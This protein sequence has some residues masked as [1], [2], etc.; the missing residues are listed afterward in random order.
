MKKRIL[1]LIQSPS[2]QAMSASALLTAL[3]IPEDEVKLFQ[4]M[5][6]SLVSTGEVFE[7]FGRYY[8]PQEAGL[9]K[10]TIS[11]KTT[12]GFITSDYFPEDL[13]V[14][15]R[16]LKS[17][18]SGDT[19][20]FSVHSFGEGEGKKLE[21][22]VE[23][24]LSHARSYV[25]GV[26]KTVRGR[27]TLELQG[28]EETRFNVTEANGAHEGDLVKAQ[29]ERQ[30]SSVMEGPI[31]QN[32][33]RASDPG[34]D[35]YG[36]A[37]SYGFS[38]DFPDEVL[39]E[40]NTLPDG[41]VFEEKKR[42]APSLPLI[43]TVDGEDTKDID[44]AVACRK[45]ADGSYTLGVYIADVSYYVR[46]E[47]SLDKE[48]LSRG[49]SVY[50]IDKVLPMLPVRLSNEL[51]SLNEGTP[52]LAEACEMHIAR[53]GRVTSKSLFETVMTSSHRMT[54][55][56]IQ[57]ILDGD[58]ETSAAYADIVNEVHAMNELAQVL[59]KMH[60]GKG[61]IDFDV[62]EAKIIVNDQGEPIDIVL[63]ERRD[64]EKIIEQFMII[65]NETVAKT[66]T[67]AHL[68]MIYRVH[69][70]PRSERIEEYNK[71]IA[72][73]GYAPLSAKPTAKEVQLFMSRIPERDEFLRSALIRAMAKACY[74]E[75]NIGHYGLASK[76][77]THFTSPIRRYPDLLVHRLLRR[78]VFRHDLPKAG[79]GTDE[80]EESIASIA[81]QASK[82]ERDATSA[83]FAADDLKKAQYMASHV[84]ETFSGVISGVQKFGFFVELANTV[85]GL[86][87]TAILPEGYALQ[88][89]PLSLACPADV[90][91]ALGDEVQVILTKADTKSGKIDFTVV[92]PKGARPC[93]AR[94]LL[95]ATSL[96]P[97]SAHHPVKTAHHDAPAAKAHPSSHAP[98]ALHAAPAKKGKG[99]DTAKKNKSS[100]TGKH[101][102]HYTTSLGDLIKEARKHDR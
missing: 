38:K 68:P 87:A 13:Y 14:F 86:V 12:F 50:M 34:N 59:T 67:D 25:V 40:A 47:T 51:C 29:I 62:P 46:P 42:K 60:E 9:Y 44:D 71:E 24:V 75:E 20:I 58:A 22:S 100:Q 56:K 81:R 11:V 55:T 36:I 52:K 88:D 4:E 1:A 70:V 85:E 17:A 45:E 3:S 49:T 84:G 30:N 23:R 90:T 7:K 10:G 21:A 82:R 76:D 93:R 66:V 79:K 92:R 19:V 96:D 33:G 35:L 18:L 32:L 73:L 91:Y 95:R 54:Y 77:Y 37:A 43:I 57:A 39:T 94:E 6:S 27:L 41:V 15:G 74:S 72:T 61:A 89:A 97:S 8:S 80:L 28:G 5:L 101:E 31:V 64:A 83:E 98:S 99:H 53:D 2:Y 26:V 16:N 48:A 63:R 78:Y 102:K 69:D 65:A